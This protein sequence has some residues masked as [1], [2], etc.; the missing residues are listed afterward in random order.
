MAM[1]KKEH[2]KIH[3]QLHESLDKLLA[4]FLIHNKKAGL[5]TSIRELIEWSHQQTIDPE[6]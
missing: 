4:D 5:T 3:K 2:I 1:N 6:E